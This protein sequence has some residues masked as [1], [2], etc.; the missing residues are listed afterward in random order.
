MATERQLLQYYHGLVYIFVIEENT[1]FE[2]KISG[3]KDL[4]FPMQIHTCFVKN[5]C[6]RV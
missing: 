3:N 1:E 6:C 4:I 5:P 2:F